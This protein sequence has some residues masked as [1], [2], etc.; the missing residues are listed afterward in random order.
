MCLST[1]SPGVGSRREE[2][3]PSDVKKRNTRA[4]EVAPFVGRAHQSTDETGNNHDL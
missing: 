2:K 1:D 4:G 3:Y